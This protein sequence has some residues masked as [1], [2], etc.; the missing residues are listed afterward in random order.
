LDGVISMIGLTF[1]NPQ[2]ECIFGALTFPAYE[3]IMDKMGARGVPVPMKEGYR[4][5]TDGF[6]SAVTSDTKMVFLCNPNNPTG[7]FVTREETDRLLR[8][9]PEN[10]I[11]VSDEA[12]YEFADDP[13]YPQTEPYLSHLPNLILLRT[14]SKI[15]GLAGLRIGYAMAHVDVVRV[16]LKARE[17]YPVNIIAQAGALASLD[18]R[19]FVEKTLAVNQRGREQYYRAFD[20]M[21]LSYCPTQTNFIFID[22]ERPARP[23]FETMLRD[24]VI[25]RPL[26]FVGAPTCLRITIGLEQENERT[27]ASLKRALGAHLP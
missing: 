4:L 25:V 24:G 15:M 5:D 8:G 11:V 17:P 12:Y 20:E 14:F 3:N 18:D 13:L 22:L 10:V 19:D 1:L 6:L 21:G 23:V 9:L 27:I 26:V 7:T 16:M 2:D